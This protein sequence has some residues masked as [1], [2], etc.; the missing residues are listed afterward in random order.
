MRRCGYLEFMQK[1]MNTEREIA[2]KKTATKTKGKAPAKGK[3][4]KL[5]EKGKEE[6]PLSK[7]EAEIK[8]LSDLLNIHVKHRNEFF[9]KSQ[10]ELGKMNLN[11]QRLE[12]AIAYVNSQLKAE[13]KK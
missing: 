13:E 3:V 12:G 5:P 8:R 11:I 6:K 1:N 4:S 10:A 9:E 2:M 7:E